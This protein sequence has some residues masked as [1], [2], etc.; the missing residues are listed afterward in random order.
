[1][2]SCSLSRAVPWTALWV[3]DKILRSV[4]DLIFSKWMSFSNGVIPGADPGKSERGVVPY[5][6]NLYC[7][8]CRRRKIFI[9]NS[10][11][12]TQNIK[13]QML[14]KGGGV[15]TPSNLPLD[16]PLNTAIPWSVKSAVRLSGIQRKSNNVIYNCTAGC[17]VFL[18]FGK[19]DFSLYFIASWSL[20]YV[21]I[22]DN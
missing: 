8:W 10:G 18:F 22:F 7:Q 11:R 13:K 2:R 6:I 9:V 19:E 12:I 20:F 15:A 14:L 4:L 1:M 21:K 16:P 17:C 5:C 3:I